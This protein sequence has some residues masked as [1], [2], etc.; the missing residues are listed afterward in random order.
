VRLWVIYCLGQEWWVDNGFIVKTL[1]KWHSWWSALC[2]GNYL[3]SNITSWLEIIF[4]SRCFKSVFSFSPCINCLFS[5][6]TLAP[7]GR[8]AVNA[9]IGRYTQNCDGRAANQKKKKVSSQ[10]LR[11]IL[12]VFYS[13][14]L[15]PSTT[16]L[17]RFVE[18]I[19]IL[20]VRMWMI[21]EKSFHH[22]L[23]CR[24]P[25]HSNW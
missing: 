7:V 24:P 8:W 25:T 5:W 16:C 11:R 13:L 9:L 1:Q 6:Q 17:Y 15:S 4:L 22:L 19:N 2:G 10:T 21:H 20:N 12:Q 3:F 23:A 18:Q 14:F